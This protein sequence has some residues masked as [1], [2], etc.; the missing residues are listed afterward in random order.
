VTSDRRPAAAGIGP[1]KIAP[2][3]LAADYTRLGE[4]VRA[5]SEA[6][7]DYIHCDVMD[8]H[9]VPPITF[10][11]LILD[12][13]RRSTIVPLDVHMMVESPERY[14][15]DVARAGATLFT[16]HIEA[17]RHIHRVV[18][19]VK[20]SGMKAGVAINPGTSVSAIEAIL[21]DADLILIMSVNPGWG[22]QPFIAEALAKVRE[23]RSMIDTLGLPLEIEV[24][25]GIVE[26]TAAAAVAAGADVLVAGSAIFNDRES[27]ADAVARLRNSIRSVT[28]KSGQTPPEST[29]AASFRRGR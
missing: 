10:G 23:V 17:T 26:D 4:Q 15:E 22:G 20:S 5:A 1:I 2:S 9:F 3:I 7:V 16:A 27:I 14:V 8:G 25:G 18:Q 29:E 12:A 24:D 21:P 13:V 28:L 6:G 19:A 11:P